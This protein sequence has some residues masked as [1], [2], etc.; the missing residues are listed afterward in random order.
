MIKNTLVKKILKNSVFK[1]ANFINRLVPKDD[2]V[3]LLYSANKGIQFSLV[4]L[5]DYLIK[6]DF[7]EKYRI[8]CGIENLKYADDSPLEFLN[9]L[10]SYIIFFR[11]KHVFY[12]AG[13]IPIKPSKNQCV[14]HLRHGNANFKRAGKLTDINNGDEFF[15]TYMAASSPIFKPIMAR[16]Y[17]CSENNI[18]V[19]GDPIIDALLEKRTS[20]LYDFGDYDKFI[21]WI[22]TFRQSDYLGYSDSTMENVVPMFEE[23]DYSIINEV[24]KNYNIKLIV[25]LH[26]AQKNNK[27][28]HWHFSN[29]GIFTHQE[30]MQMGYDINS[31]M[32]HSDALIGDYSSASMQYLVLDRPQAFVVP[33]IEE[34]GQK[35]G[36]V[37]ERPE[38]YMG[39]HIIKNI[40]QFYKFIE[41]IA[42]G[43]DI[44]AEKRRKI[45]KKIYTYLDNQNCKRVVEL[46]GMK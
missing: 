24:L 45:C 15:F 1:I 46:S 25:K 7:H 4:P 2:K 6:N 40:N 32:A 38:D 23:K 14:I 33:D 11:A 22:P 13:Q 35:R 16:E 34:Y 39:G 17:A 3:V 41:D 42:A 29:L 30:F 19:V 27:K 44:Y 8:I 28:T 21:L 26:P 10:G 12:T 18:V 43:N 37:F 36:F 5:R 20:P 9:R 31:I